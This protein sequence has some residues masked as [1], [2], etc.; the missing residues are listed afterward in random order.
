VAGIL[1]TTVCSPVERELPLKA[2]IPFS[3]PSLLDLTSTVAVDPSLILEISRTPVE[4]KDNVGKDVEF[5]PLI[6]ADHWKLGSKFDTGTEKPP[7]FQTGR[8]KLGN[9]GRPMATDTDD[10][11]LK[12]PSEVDAIILAK[13]G[14]TAVTSPSIPTVA[15]LGLEVL[16]ITVDPADPAGRSVAFNLNVSPVRMLTESAS[17]AIPEMP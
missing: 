7:R 8:P 1:I 17:M 4:S 10:C 12:R 9:S 2:V 5:D 3:Y 13:P 11:A 16:Q 14:P 15:T 6:D